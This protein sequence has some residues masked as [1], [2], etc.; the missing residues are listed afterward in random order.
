MRNRQDRLKRLGECKARLDAKAHRAHDDQ[1]RKLESR[2]IEEKKT[3]RKKRDR[4]L[5]YRGA[6]SKTQQSYR[7]N[8]RCPESP[9]LAT[10]KC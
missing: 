3:G 8:S 9:I 2:E 5:T 1:S 10:S 7:S 6:I 4:G